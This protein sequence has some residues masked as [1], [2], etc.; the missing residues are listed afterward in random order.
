MA[1][2]N[3]STKTPFFKKIIIIIIFFLLICCAII[4]YNL[5]RFIFQPNIYLGEKQTTYIYIPTN[6]NLK[7][8]VN[9]LLKEDIIIN[10]NSFEWLA[11]KSNYK[12][13]IHPGKYLIK[14]GMNNKE[15]IGLL[16]S[17]R[18]K[19]VQLTFNNIRTKQRFIGRIS[20]QIEA[21]SLSLANLFNNSEYLK[22]FN[23]TS[24]NFMVIFIPN[25]YEFY[26]NTSA[27]TFFE[28]MYKEYNKLWTT[29]RKEKAANIG[30]TQIEV[31][32]LASIVEQEAKKVEEMSRIA[33]V[34]MNR[35]HK[36]MLLQADPTVI[37]AIGDYSIRRLYN[38]HEKINS[39]YN[40]YKYL[41]LP[42]GPICL[43]NKRT[44]DAVLNYEKHKYLFFCAK[45]DLSG[46]H[47][48]E[49][50]Y[51]QHKINAGKYQKALNKLNIE[52]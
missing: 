23:L 22:K 10:P 3:T 46:Y 29:E 2:K 41:G 40:T 48:F 28:R 42:P 11:K 35:L 26:W 31:S 30:L 51:A 47:N 27:E 20:K 19:P 18:Q 17:G 50:T 6:S 13:H 39:P 52:K 45:E 4:A 9:I 43:P 25:T 15:L 24:D 21:D 32:I 12:N 34:Y 1:R 33:G 7:E 37:F 36:N 8:V 44:I 16:Y 49:E 38:N 5:Y 14:A